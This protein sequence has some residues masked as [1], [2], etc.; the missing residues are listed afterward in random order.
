[1][2]AS[3]WQVRKGAHGPRKQAR[4]QTQESSFL[5]PENKHSNRVK[6]RIQPPIAN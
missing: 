5:T 6:S 3:R 1:M 2:G 4:G